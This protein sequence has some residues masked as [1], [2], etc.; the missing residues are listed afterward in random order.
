MKV[1]AIN[2][3]PRKKWNTYTLLEK[4]LEGATSK[5]AET[6]LINLYDLD[7]KGCVSCFYCKRKG[8]EHGK[9]ALK[10]DISPIIEKLKDVDAIVFGSPIYFMNMTAGLTA[11]LERFLFSNFLYDDQYTSQLNKKIQSG[12][13]Y[14]MNITE[15][16]AKTVELSRGYQFYERAIGNVLG[17]QPKSLY[18]YNTYQFADYSKYEASFFSEEDKAKYKE[19]QFPI[20]CENA[21]NMGVEFANNYHSKSY[22]L[23]EKDERHKV[24]FGDGQ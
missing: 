4:V 20:D 11:F 22:E 12:I 23:V 16:L 10:D 17:I 8:I 14:T 3:S 18:A 24:D 5:G 13:I 21:F 15:E 1:V 9:C 7:F 19:E 2:G 6:E